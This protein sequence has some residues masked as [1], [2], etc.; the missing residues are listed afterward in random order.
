MDIA[1]LVCEESSPTSQPQ[2]HSIPHAHAV[3]YVP[4][5]V[6]SQSTETILPSIAIQSAARLPV[7]QVPTR[8]VTCVLCGKSFSGVSSHNRHV[9]RTHHKARP[10]GCTQCPKSFGQKGSLERHI[11]GVHRKERPYSCD[12]CSKGFGRSDNLRIHVSTVHMK[13]RPYKCTACAKSFGGK[14]PLT[15]HWQTVHL[16]QRPLECVLCARRFGQRSNLNAHIRQVHKREPGGLKAETI[17]N[18]PCSP[19]S[20]VAPVQTM[21]LHTLSPRANVLPTSPASSADDSGVTRAD[22]DLYSTVTE[23]NNTTRSFPEYQAAASL[24]PPP[25][26]Y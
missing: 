14:R 20:L 18:T 7:P 26:G 3:A 13:Q 16:K 1:A 5:E 12:F 22:S 2:T 9:S 15:I 11:S 6:R 19:S 24:W 8:R 17:L 4:E 21:P 25:Q 23:D 10:F